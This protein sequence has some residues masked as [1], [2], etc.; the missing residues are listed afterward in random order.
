MKGRLSRLLAIESPIANA[1][2]ML[3][4]LEPQDSCHQE[5]RRKLYS[6]SYDKPFVVDNGQRRFLHFDFD[7]IQSAMEVSNPER[8]A[9][10]YT[11]KM[12][13]FLLF[14]RTPERI[15]LLGLGGGSLAKFCYS[16]LPA[17]SITAVEV[18][19]DVIA[20]RDEFSIPADDHRFRVINADG[21]AYVSA[22][23]ASQGRDP[24]RRL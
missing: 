6:G 16:K 15:L 9:L 14:N 23:Y 18:N 19:E 22:A 1:N 21:G 24:R 12:M 4:L 11:R 17:A 10:A 3:R 2:V 20:L 13:A 5:L 7:A 8:L